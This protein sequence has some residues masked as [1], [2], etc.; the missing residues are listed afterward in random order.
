LISTLEK[1][2]G[3]GAAAGGVCAKA[4]PDNAIMA[5]TAAILTWCITTPCGDFPMS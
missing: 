1:S 4:G 5:A 3:G 2:G